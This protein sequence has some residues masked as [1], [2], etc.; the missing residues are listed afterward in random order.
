MIFLFKW[1]GPKAPKIELQSGLGLYWE[2]LEATWGLLGRSWRHF[3]R[4]GE[5]LGASWVELGASWKGFGVS[6]APFGLIMGSLGRNLGGLGGFQGRF[7]KHSWRISV[8][9]KQFMKIVKNLGKPVVFHRFS[10]F[11]KSSGFQ[12]SPK[13]LKKIEVCILRGQEIPKMATWRAKGAI[14]Q[15]K[16]EPRGRFWRPKTT[17]TRQK[18]KKIFYVLGFWGKTELRRRPLSKA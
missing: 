5:L 6:W 17:Q 8:H 11:W 10:R 4:L 9:L 2:V 1:V 3:G 7:W 12:K 13:N 14:L 15:R 16:L 18:L